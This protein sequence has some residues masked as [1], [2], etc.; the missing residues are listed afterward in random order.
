MHAVPMEARRGC[1]D[2]AELGDTEIVSP[3]VGAGIVSRYV[4]AGSQ[5]QVLQYQQVF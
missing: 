2:P 1:W 5:T 3:C 4:G